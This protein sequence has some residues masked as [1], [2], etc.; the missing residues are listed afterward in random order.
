MKYCCVKHTQQLHCCVKHEEC[1]LPVFGGDLSWMEF[2]CAQ[3]LTELQAY[4]LIMNMNDAHP[5]SAPKAKLSPRI[6]RMVQRRKEY[7]LIWND[8]DAAP[9]G[10]QALW[11]QGALQRPQQACA[12]RPQALALS[13]KVCGELNENTIASLCVLNGRSGSSPAPGYCAETDT[14]QRNTK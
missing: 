8:I 11:R 9:R 14:S 3:M 2:C 13:R 4:D 1:P 5:R 6:A 12:A 10:Y 7:N